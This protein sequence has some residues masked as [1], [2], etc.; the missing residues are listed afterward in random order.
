MIR[1][2]ENNIERP[3]GRL[4][5]TT[6]TKKIIN[7]RPVRKRDLDVFRRGGLIVETRKG[8]IT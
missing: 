2:K 5:Y 8:D 6:K 1:R 4:V 7:Y 3:C